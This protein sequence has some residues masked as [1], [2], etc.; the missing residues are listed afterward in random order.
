MRRG[1]T[2]IELMVASVLLGMLAA[3]L[4]MVFNQSSIAWRTGVAGIVNLNDSRAALGTAHDICDELLPGLGDDRTAS[5]GGSDGRTVK[6]RTVSLWD[7]TK[8][9]QLRMR[10]QRAFN[11]DSKSINWGK[12]RSFS[13]S[14]AQT[15]NALS[16]VGAGGAA[17]EARNYSVG[18]RSLGPDGDPDTEDDISTWPEEID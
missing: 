6:Y 10:S 4:T 18:V 15:A 2:L 14:D 17:N 16:V 11:F 9:N 13:M 3:I 12:A 7:G 1:F 8:Q 5:D